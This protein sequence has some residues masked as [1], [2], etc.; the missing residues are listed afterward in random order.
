MF[1]K[2]P[3]T[4]I[5]KKSNKNSTKIVKPDYLD[6][7]SKNMYK[8]NHGSPKNCDNIK[9]L[10]IKKTNINTDQHSNSKNSDELFD[11]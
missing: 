5:T 3:D 9:K 6:K 10:Y 11:D 8:S 1:V 4:V 7:N 2:K